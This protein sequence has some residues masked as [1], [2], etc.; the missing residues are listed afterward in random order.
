MYI[1]SVGISNGIIEK[2]YGGYGTNFN[3][4]NIPTYSLPFKIEEAPK[5]TISFAFILED[6]DAYAVTGFQWIHWLGANLLRNELKENESQTAA[7]FI[8]GANSWISIQGNQQSRKQSSYYGGMTP[9]DKSHTYE[10]HVFALDKKLCIENG[11]YLNELWKQ[12]DGHIIE[13]AVLKGI[14]EKVPF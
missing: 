3:E 6:K 4:N 5:N 8:Q 9:P 13:E 7:D 14:Y 11:F 10:L 1:S 12:M 2:K